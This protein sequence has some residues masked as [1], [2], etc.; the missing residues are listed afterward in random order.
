V[1]PVEP[2]ALQ[3]LLASIRQGEEAPAAAR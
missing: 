1:K 3:A 2:S